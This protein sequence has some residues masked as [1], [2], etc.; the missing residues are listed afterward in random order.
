MAGWLNPSWIHEDKTFR[1]SSCAGRAW[2]ER[3]EMTRMMT[4]G[5]WLAWHG[6]KCPVT[7]LTLQSSSCHLIMNLNTSVSQTR[8]AAVFE[9]L[10]AGQAP[11]ASCLIMRWWQKN[12]RVITAPAPPPGV[13]LP[14]TQIAINQTGH[15][16][17]NLPGHP[18]RLNY[19]QLNWKKEEGEQ[20]EEGQLI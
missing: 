12:N 10:R 18:L 8:W 5:D 1:D 14:K 16:H 9:L 3:L 4:A 6:S 19:L 13:S 2:A 17:H 7:A 15:H 20:R 11:G